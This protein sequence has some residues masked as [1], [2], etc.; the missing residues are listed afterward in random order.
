MKILL[1]ED[2]AALA[3]MSRRLLADVYEHE[4]THA[5][6]GRDALACAQTCQPDLALID[7][8]LPDM[9]G[10][11]LAERIR[12]NP[13][14]EN[15]VLVALTGWGNLMDGDRAQSAGFDAQFRKP[16]DFEMLPKL[17]RVQRLV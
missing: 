12:R 15:T 14:L 11:E 3:D 16:M 2:H 13:A 4:V 5:T 10:Y 9:D 17:K 6:C 8:N 7:I 1:V